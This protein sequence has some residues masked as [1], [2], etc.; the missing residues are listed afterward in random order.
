MR[1]FRQPLRKWFRAHPVLI[2]EREPNKGCLQ[3]YQTNR[4]SMRFLLF[5]ECK[6]N[7]TGQSF[8]YGRRIPLYRGIAYYQVRACIVASAYTEQD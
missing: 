3:P 1:E 6:N 4:L 7:S 5:V 2:Y 8:K